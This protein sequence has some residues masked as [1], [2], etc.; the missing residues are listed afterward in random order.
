MMKIVCLI[1]SLTETLIDCGVT[2]VGRT[3]Y[4]LHP[5]PVVQGIPAIGGTKQVDWSV[6]EPLEPDLVILDREE[7]TR[8]MA[9]SC[10][11]PHHAVHITSVHDVGAQ[12]GEL[13]QLLGSSSLA[14]VAIRWDQVVAQ[15]RKNRQ[16]AELPG[17]LQWWRPP[18]G[19]T[20]AEYLIWRRPWM[21]IGQGTFIHSMLAQVG[22]AGRLIPHEEKYPEVQLTD[23]DPATTALLFS[24][25]PYP[26]A[27]D[28]EE[29]LDLGFSCG[30]I[31]GES[32]S[33]YGTRSLRF[34]EEL[35]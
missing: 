18:A 27:R 21:A 35:G 2:V 33:W 25:E 24:S 12:L 29:L 5:A 22:L 34:L 13:A 8:E 3:R 31:D 4:C 11:F 15:P 7:N 6:A 17:M 1:P 28:R 32:Y 26:F 10:P 9:D 16:L 30:L 14:E 23:L 20:R 19:Q